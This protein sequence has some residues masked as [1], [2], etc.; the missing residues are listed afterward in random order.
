MSQENTPRPETARERYDNTASR[1]DLITRLL[2]RPRRMAVEALA[3]R[4]SIGHFQAL[5]LSTVP[6]ERYR[7]RL[8]RKDFSARTT[9]NSC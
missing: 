4:D 6:T 8:S 3:L 2:A 5:K 9:R 7:A 1:Y